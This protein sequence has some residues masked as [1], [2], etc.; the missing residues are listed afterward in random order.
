[1]AALIVDALALVTT[2][3][4]DVCL[5]DKQLPGVGGVSVA[6]AIRSN[7]PDAVI[8]FVTGQPTTASADELVGIADEYL[9]K[10]FDLDTLRETVSTLVAGRKGQRLSQPSPVPTRASGKKWV[11]L[12]CNDAA[13]KASVE[14]SC[15]TLDA[16][17]TTGPSLPTEP[18]DVLVMSAALASFEMRKGIWGFQ[19][20]KRG[21]HV[22]LVTDPKSA[23]DSAAAVALKAT[24]RITLPAKQEQAHQ[25]LSSALK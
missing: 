6:R 9:S 24:W 20:R 13:V 5:V 2:K 14:A 11:H 3:T 15:K 7:T 21:F 22:V 23:G 8:I 25:V 17:L 18:P 4:F 12:V 19:A 1:L 10:P 16:Q